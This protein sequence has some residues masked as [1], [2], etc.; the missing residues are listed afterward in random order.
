MEVELRVVI[1]DFWMQSCYHP[2]GLLK[3]AILYCRSD[4]NPLIQLVKVH[5]RFDVCL[6]GELFRCLLEPLCDGR[7]CYL[8]MNYGV[9]I[10][11]IELACAAVLVSATAFL[12]LNIRT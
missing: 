4:A 7:V 9:F 6:N 11:S 5:W 12:G 8:E 3:L 2:H 10:C 1:Q